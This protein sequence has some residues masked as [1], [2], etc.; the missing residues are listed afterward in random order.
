VTVVL[1][2]ILLRRFAYC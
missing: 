1:H 2:W